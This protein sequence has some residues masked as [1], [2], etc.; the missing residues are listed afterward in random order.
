MAADADDEAG[1]ELAEFFPNTATGGRAPGTFLVSYGS[2]AAE[3]AGPVRVDD[4]AEACFCSG[5][6]CV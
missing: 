3:A 1:V 5:G 4:D 6:V 2:P